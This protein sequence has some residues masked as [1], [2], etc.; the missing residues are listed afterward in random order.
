MHEL[1]FRGRAQSMD[2]RIEEMQIGFAKVCIVVAAFY[3]LFFIFCW[4]IGGWDGSKH[5]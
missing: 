5:L 4:L 2:E 1:A 3:G